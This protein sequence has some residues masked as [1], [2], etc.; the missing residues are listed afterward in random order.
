[1]IELILYILISKENVEMMM[2][3]IMEMLLCLAWLI[4]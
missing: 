3:K 4:C 1:L 2:L